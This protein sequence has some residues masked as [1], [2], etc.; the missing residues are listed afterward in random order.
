[1]GGRATN[2]VFIDKPDTIFWA[3]VYQYGN[4][5]GDYVLRGFCDAG[6]KEESKAIF[7]DTIKAMVKDGKFPYSL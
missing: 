5:N 3:W 7:P 6:L 4:E 1:M 2:I